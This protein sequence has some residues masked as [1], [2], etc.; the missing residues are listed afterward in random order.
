MLQ[1]L[2]LIGHCASCRGKLEAWT[3]G[4]IGQL[5]L[6]A[7]RRVQEFCVLAAGRQRR[8]LGLGKDASSLSFPLFAGTINLK[9]VFEFFISYPTKPSQEPDVP[10]PVFATSGNTGGKAHYLDAAAKM[11]SSEL[12]KDV[13]S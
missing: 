3:T 2:V 8:R 5:G 7:S 11:T 10:I 9:E 6:F 12:I 4:Q 1:H 13:D